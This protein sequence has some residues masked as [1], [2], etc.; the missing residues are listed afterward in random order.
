MFSKTFATSE[1]SWDPYT[2]Q[3]IEGGG[4]EEAKEN[5]EGPID[6]EDE[7][8]EHKNEETNVSLEDI[9]VENVIP[10]EKERNKKEKKIYF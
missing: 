6:E 3:V 5:R 10:I 8:I 2:S 1:H 4:Q 7:D 9:E